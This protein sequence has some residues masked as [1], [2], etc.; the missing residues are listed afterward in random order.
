MRITLKRVVYFLGAFVLFYIFSYW[1]KPPLIINNVDCSKLFYNLDDFRYL[2]CIRA[3]NLKSVQILTEYYPFASGRYDELGRAPFE[4]CQKETR[5][6]AFRYTNTY[7]TPLE[8]SDGVILHMP[9]L[10]N[11][12]PREIYRRNAKQLW[13]MYTMEAQR[14]SYC[15]FN[16]TLNDLD[17]WFN[18][19]QTTK[20]QSYNSNDLKQLY[21]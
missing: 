16:N 8:D 1:F 21:R 14:F 11:L 20:T 12:P 7:Q 13:F 2:A 5:C 15:F 9:D 19:T 10:V 18:L 4:Y 17:D 6:Y 3:Q